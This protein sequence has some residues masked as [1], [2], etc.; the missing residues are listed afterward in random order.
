VKIRAII[1]SILTLGVAAQSYG[2]AMLQ[3]FNQSWNEI[4]AKMPEIAEAGYQSLWLPPPAKANSQF[5]AGYDIFDPFDL[6]DKDQKGTIA[7]RYGTKAELIHMVEVA[8]RFGIRVYFDNI[9]NHRSYD[10]PGYDANTPITVYP[11]ML[12]EDFHL[13]LTSDG[14][15]RKWDNVANWSDV[16]QI[17][18]RNFSDLIDIAQ[19]SEGAAGNENGNFGYNEGDHVVKLSFVR[20]PHNPE[21]YEYKPDGSFVGFGNVTQSDLD[22]NAN[23]YKEDVGGYLIRAARWF[24]ATSKCDGLRLDAVKHVPAYFFGDTFDSPNGYTGGIQAEFDSAHGYYPTIYTEGDDNRNS[25]FDAEAVRNDALIFGEHLGEPPS[26]GDY[27]SRGMRLVDSPLVN[28]LNNILGNSYSSLAGLDQRNYDGYGPFNAANRVMYVQSHDN[29]Y[30]N[31]RELQLAYIFM[32]EGIPDI[33]SDG[34][35]LSSTCKECGGEFPRN[36]YAS[37]LG[38]FGDNKMPELVTLHGELARGG[39]RARWSDADVV[40]FERYDYREGTGDTYN[41]PNLTTVLFAMNDNYGYPGDISFD[42]GVAQNDA[43][44]P[45]TCYPVQN[46]RGQGLVVS[47]PPGSVLAQLSTSAPGSER[48]CPKLLVRYATNDKQYATDHSY[49]NPP[50]TRPIYVGSQTIPPGGGAIEFKVPSGGYVMYGYQPPEASRAVGGAMNRDVVTL[51]QDGQIAPRMN[52]LRSTGPD[53]DVNYDPIYPFQRRGSV[54]IYGNVIG[55]N[56]FSNRT[57]SIDV[58]VLTNSTSFNMILRCDASAQNILVKLDGGTDINSQMAIGPTSQMTGSITDNRDNRPGYSYDTFLGYEQPAFQFRAGPEKFAAVDTSRNTVVSMGAETY[59]YTLGGGS[60][61]VNGSGPNYS[62]STAAWVYHKPDDTTDQAQTMRSPLTPGGADS[63]TIWVKVGY[64]NL[65]NAGNVYYTTDD[66]NPEGAYGQPRRGTTTQVVPLTFDHNSSGGNDTYDWW[67]ATI[68]AQGSG[69]VRYKIALYKTG[70]DP[71]SDSDDAKY[72]GVTQ[73]AI[74]NFNPQT[75]RVWLHDDLNTNSTVVGLQPGYHVLRAR[76]FLPRDGKSS[77]YDTFTQT[78]YY[79]PTLPTGIFAYPSNG[80]T[81]YSKNYGVVVRTDDNV[82]SVQY[83]IVD[84]DP[85]NNSTTNGNGVGFYATATRVSPMP[86]YPSYPREFR[87]NYVG[88]PSNGTATIIARL[89]GPTSGAFSNRFTAIT[90]QVYCAAPSIAFDIRCPTLDCFGSDQSTISLDQNDTFTIVTCFSDFLDSGD[91]TKFSI[92]VDGSLQ[93]RF[94]PDGTPLYLISDTACGAGKHDLRYAWGGMSAGSHLIEVL[95]D[96]PGNG[97]HVQDSAI[98]NVTL[99]GVAVNIIQPPAADLNGVSPYTIILPD[100]TNATPADRSF[101][102]TTETSLSVTNVDISFNVITNA[103]TGGPATLDTNFV[104]NVKHWNFNWTNLYPGTFLIRADA[105]GGGSNTAYRTVKVIFTQIISGCATNDDDCDDDGIINDWES[106]PQSLPGTLSETWNNGDVHKWFMSGKSDPNNPDTDNDNLPDGL[107]LGVGPGPTGSGT[108]TNADTNGDGIKNFTPDLDPPIY[109]TTDNASRPAGYDSYGTWRYDLNKSRTDLIAGTVTDPGRPDTDYDGLMDGVEDA[110]HNGR[111]DIGL[112]NASGVVTNIIAH[113]ATIYNTSIIDRNQILL[114]ASNAVW[115]E[116]D[117]NNNDTDGD[118]LLDGSEDSNHNGILDVGLLDRPRGYSTG[119]ASVTNTLTKAQLAPYLYVAGTSRINVQALL[120]AIPNAVLLETN[121]M[122]SDTDG[123]GLPDGWEVAHGFD[124]WDDGTIGHT[125]LHSGAIITT[126]LNGANGDPDGDGCNNLC[127]YQNGTDPWVSNLLPPPPADSVTIGPGQA[128]GTTGGVTW[129]QEFQDWRSSDVKALDEYDGAGYLKRGRDVYPFNDGYDWSRDIVAFYARDGG[130]DGKYYFRVDFHD[131]QYKAEQGFLDIYVVINFGTPADENTANIT[132]PD[133]IDT[134]TD[135]GWKLVVA[136]YDQNNGSVYVKLPGSAQGAYVTRGSSISG[137]GFLGS[138]YRSDLD[139]CEFAISRQALLDA[140]WNG[141]SPLTFQVF[142]TKD[143][144][145]NSC[146]GGSPGPGDTPKAGS[147]IT[148]SIYDD[149]IA[150]SDSPSPPNDTLYHWFTSINCYPVSRS[151]WQDG[152]NYT[153]RVNLAKVAILLHANQADLP[154]SVIQSLLYNPSQLTPT[155]SDTNFDPGHNPTGY[156]R[157]LDSAQVFN[158]PLN[159]HLSG[160]LVTALQWAQTPTPNDPQSGPAFN[161]RIAGMVTSGQAALV[162]GMFAD[163]IATEFNGAVNRTGVQ[164]QDDLLR[165][166]Y[167]S[168]SISASTPIYL[169]E[170][171][172]DGPTLSDVASNSGH[173]YTVLD[174]MVHLWWWGEQLWGLGNGRQAALSDAGYQLNRFNGM[175]AFLIS[176]ASDQMYSVNDLGASISLRELL[177]RKALSGTRDQV[178]VLADNWETAGGYDGSSAANSNPD[179]LNLVLRWIANHQWIQPVLLNKFANGQLDINN[180]GAVNGSDAPY[181]NDRGSANYSGQA[182]DYVRHAS[183]SDYNNWYYGSGQEES[184]YSKQVSNSTGTASTKIIGHVASNGTIYADAWL[185]AQYASGALSNLARLVYLNGIF[186]TAFHNEDNWNYARYSTGD[187]KN[188]DT[189]YDSIAGLALR[190]NLRATRQASVVAAAAAWS[191]SN[192]STTPIATQ[193][194]V[195]QDG[196][197]EYLLYNNRVFAAF[198]RKGGRL[199]AAFAR[200]PITGAT[201]QMSG[202]LVATPDNSDKTE[203][204]TNLSGLNPVAYR[205]SGLK[206][207]FTI[208]NGTGT[209]QYV[210]DVYDVVPAT[211]AT[212]WKLKSSDNH[213]QKTVTLASSSDKLEVSYNLTDGATTNYVRMGLSPDLLGLLYSGQQYLLGPSNTTGRVSLRQLSPRVDA[214]VAINY[215]DAGHS[216]VTYNAAA[217]D[218]TNAWNTVNMRNQAQTQQIELQ[219][220]AQNFSFAIEFTTIERGP[221]VD[222]VGDGIPDW[223]RAQYFPNVDPAGLTTNSQSAATADPDGDGMTNYGEYIAGTS[224]VDPSSALRILSIVRQTN[225]NVDVTW[226]SVAG[227]RYVVLSSTNLVTTPFLPASATNT[228][229]SATSTFT[230][231]S[232]DGVRNFYKVQVLP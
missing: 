24:V 176:G 123:D 222:H 140:G 52:L 23:Y 38:E 39:S 152:F 177:V 118:G 139:S 101:T 7:T 199:L 18:H 66:T 186:E 203:G 121:P 149:E 193:Q 67:K 227:K 92:K 61:I 88:I 1:I 165:S 16:W 19:E 11:G 142:T 136:A 231:S 106:T 5:S 110:N 154:S 108:A 214:T 58:P 77:V 100:S 83:N 159:L 197:N 126:T 25:C 205:T 122:N 125:N 47:F 181:I 81:L 50:Y 151:N 93:P 147:D 178:V 45:S 70:I 91:I 51:Q 116:T 217:T 21:Y 105:T 74:T 232:P 6:G 71:I 224:P 37:Y 170:R 196:E 8:H 40:A 72:Y 204:D 80:D 117:P 109:N 153:N 150:E 10:V 79:D 164:L 187:Y 185:D 168:N 225:G 162:T 208:V 86:G 160:S 28:S 128:I 13:R 228:E 229:M 32:R 184:L 135:M 129:Y 3:L 44:M 56:N 68:P 35:R 220:G 146:Y 175:N 57:Y 96:D 99:T 188:P 14:F 145:C 198:E 206:D 219:G 155:G 111:V 230:D 172:V 157:V 180:D 30:S 174:Q 94:A 63:V 226:S 97:I 4:A 209:I 76:T 144:T 42:D 85:S 103:F 27:T 69:T 211:G 124:P 210:N 65:I 41:N 131:L 161:A 49:D 137:N 54:D 15:F 60:N 29:G 46:T 84:G 189:T 200:D 195:D 112:T 141:G 173:N 95:Y 2:E 143:G 31:H 114:Y 215:A 201:Y 221:T 216:N 120:A 202:N 119:T 98:V 36:A 22:N 171:V 190:P 12:P 82:D 163:H 34:W 194:D 158:V 107:E 130:S 104:G 59:W 182:R 75:C 20:Q 102:I 64:Q 148:D 55:G 17:Q 179:K 207:W 192:P 89:N 183:E 90:N 43:G 223:W 191:A 156:S 212:G 73:F 48:A 213:I 115:L 113:P 169:A 53:G 26:F 9:M 167:G 132:L 127:E 138:Y 218:K 33:Y 62:T 134:K 78:F 133:E 87:F 166:V